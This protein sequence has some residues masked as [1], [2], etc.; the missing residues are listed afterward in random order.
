M[1]L[2]QIPFEVFKKNRNL[3]Q[4]RF[5]SPFSFLVEK[6]RTPTTEGFPSKGI[7]FWISLV[8]FKNPF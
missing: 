8:S 7:L 4:N 1:P 3:P 2:I 5:E 6:I